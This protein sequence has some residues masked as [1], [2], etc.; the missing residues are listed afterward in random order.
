MW[1][2]TCSH[3]YRDILRGSGEFFAVL[4][5]DSERLTANTCVV[6]LSQVK[7]FDVV[8]RRPENNVAIAVILA[9]SRIARGPVDADARLATIHQAAVS[10]RSSLATDPLDAPLLPTHPLDV[11]LLPAHVMEGISTVSDAFSV[12]LRTGRGK[13]AGATNVLGSPTKFGGKQ[14]TASSRVAPSVGSAPSVAA[15]GSYDTLVQSE[16]PSAVLLQTRGINVGGVDVVA[17]VYDLTE[18][19]SLPHCDDG[20]CD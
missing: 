1:L 7:V 15:I 17:S 2:Q 5:F 11:P 16:N 19:A 3:S 9:S 20:A 18:K 13:A 12:L 10:A 4:A 8:Y 6:C 14:G